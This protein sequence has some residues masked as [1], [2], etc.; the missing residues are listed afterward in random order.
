M[1]KK[2]SEAQKW[3]EN[4]AAA[5]IEMR[6]TEVRTSG[7]TLEEANIFVEE[8]TRLNLAGIG[9]FQITNEGIK[10]VKFS[11]EIQKIIADRLCQ[12]K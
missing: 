7:M 4:K 6:V 11:E 5:M 3:F 12:K 2:K 8:C 9:A 10:L 1:S